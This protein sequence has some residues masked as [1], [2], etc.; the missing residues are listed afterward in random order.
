MMR[1][2][3]SKTARDPNRI[4][5]DPHRVLETCN[6]CGCETR[7]AVSIEI[8]QESAQQDT[9]A[10]SREPYR[11]SVCERCNRSERL[12]MNNQ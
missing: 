6:E 2:T 11:V 8:H 1:E 10:Y 3:M 9:A 7:H 5:Q 12:R 4:L